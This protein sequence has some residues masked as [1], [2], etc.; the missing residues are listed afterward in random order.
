MSSGPARGDD[1]ELANAELHPQLSH[2]R[3]RESFG[4]LVAA[5][6]PIEHSRQRPVASQVARWSTTRFRSYGI[7]C[8][9][10]VPIIRRLRGVVAP[11]YPGCVHQV[12]RVV[13]SAQGYWY[14]MMPGV[15]MVATTVPAAE[16]Q[17]Q[18]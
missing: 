2:I 5:P 14:V 12:S 3:G 18:A 13:K 15:N 6:I 11:R 8:G 1:S 10:L 9:I 7:E 16:S 4:D 17:P